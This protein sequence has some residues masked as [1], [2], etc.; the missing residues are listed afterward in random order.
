MI[1]LPCIFFWCL[2]HCTFHFVPDGGEYRTYWNDGLLKNTYATGKNI[3]ESW[4]M[5]PCCL[6]G[7]TWVF[8]LFHGLSNKFRG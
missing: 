1:I 2:E 7:W 5:L 4:W 8:L 3:T 6:A